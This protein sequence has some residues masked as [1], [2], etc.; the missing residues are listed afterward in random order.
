MTRSGT[1]IRWNAVQS[2]LK[3]LIAENTTA[4][5]IG[6]FDGYILGELRKEIN[7]VPFLID[8]DIEGLKIAKTKD[9]CP[10]LA[11]GTYIPLKNSSIEMILCLD[12]IEHIHHTK[13]FLKEMADIVK[14]DGFLVLTTPVANRKLVFFMSAKQME[15]IHL[16][17]GHVKPGYILKELQYLFK[18]VNLKIISI[19]QYFNTLS[20]YLYYLL[21]ICH[22]PI[23]HRI[24]QVLFKIGLWSERFVRIGG[25]EHL[26]VAKKMEE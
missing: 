16:Q 6:A 3:E 7:F 11:L 8:I 25:F 9:I 17:W 13:I 20:R 4:V 22:L 23:P 1:L 10:I 21:F 18:E 15:R 12:V 14:N 5:D 26:I 19:S 24:K 2:L